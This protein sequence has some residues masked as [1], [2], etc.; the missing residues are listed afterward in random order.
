M[1]KIKF[2]AVILVYR[3]IEDLIECIESF[4]ENLKECKIVIVNA[5]Y[6]EFT[7]TKIEEIAKKYDCDFIN[8][9]NKGYSYGNN[10]GI[11]YVN[12]HYEYKYI[13]ISNPDIV[14]KKF[15]DISLSKADIIAPKIIAKSGKNQNPMYVCDNRFSEYFIYRGFK[16]NISFLIFIGIG[17]NKILREGCICVNRFF[18]RNEYKIYV[19]HGSFLFLSKKCISEL[20]GEPYDE[21]MFLFSEECVLAY[22]AKKKDLVTIYT[23]SVEVSHKEDGSMKL[24]G[25]SINN[26]L[27]DS[28]IYFYENYR[29]K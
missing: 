26:M 12:E 6:D 7:K 16:Y 29:M 21:N 17:I 18:N 13:I 22:K 3:N 9:E 14:I 15:E 11:N 19:A 4:Y 23:E 25:F 2:V 5:Y 20:D 1:K 28:N 27:K 24:S 8:I 10:Y